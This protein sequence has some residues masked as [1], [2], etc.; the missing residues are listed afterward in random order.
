MKTPSIETIRQTIEGGANA[1]IRVG[2]TTAAALA[3]VACEP[4]ASATQSTELPSPSATEV[5]QSPDINSI[6]IEK[7]VMPENLAQYETMTSTQFEQLPLD[8]RQVYPSW[9]MRDKQEISNLF[10]RALG[11]D[12]TFALPGSV[13]KKNSAQEASNVNAAYLI[14]AVTSHFNLKGIN[15]NTVSYDQETAIKILSAGFAD[16]TSQ[17]YLDAKQSLLTA[18]GDGLLRNA[19][20]LGQASNHNLVIPLVTTDL[21]LDT[22]TSNAAG[23]NI[24]LHSMDYTYTDPTGSTFIGSESLEYVDFT[25]YTGA[26]EGTWVIFKNLNTN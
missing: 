24:T 14:N 17:E 2:L 21:G 12:A 10:V 16:T 23:E 22:S 19:G 5:S 6:P 9:L 20:P 4:H 1:A 15:G 8:E 13:S 7:Q 26:P 3:L 25:D 11:G 18:L